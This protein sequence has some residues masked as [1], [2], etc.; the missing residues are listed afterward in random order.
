MGRVDDLAGEAARLENQDPGTGAPRRWS[1]CGASI[2][3]AGHVHRSVG[4]QDAFCLVSR[5]DSPV[6]TVADGHGAAA[7]P[8]SAQGARLAADLLAKHL[9]ACDLPDGLPEATT[10]L[11]LTARRFVAQWRAAVLAAASARPFTPD[12]RAAL[13]DGTTTR[14]AATDDMAVRGYGTTVLGVRVAGGWVGAIAIGDG[15]IG[16]VDVHGQHRTLC[17][18][19]QKIGVQTDSLASP[20]PLA[21]VRVDACPTDSLV[22]AWACTDGFSDAQADPLWRDLVGTQLLRSLQERGPAG[23]ATALDGWLAPAASVG[24]DTTMALVLA[25]AGPNVS[26]G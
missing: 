2:V 23:I 15:D 7:H 18:M 26:C 1:V 24:D 9:A 22:A 14:S 17:P 10:A 11:T 16:C 5:P 25:D 19:P 20:D 3:G 21:A 13:A 8:R 12:E 4:N 6:V